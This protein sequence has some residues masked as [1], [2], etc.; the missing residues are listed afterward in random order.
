MLHSF[1][2][3]DGTVPE[4]ELVQGEDGDLYG[5]A[6]TGGVLGGGTIFK[7]SLSGT[8]T[9]LRALGGVG[10]GVGATPVGALIHAAD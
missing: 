10:G 1:S 2:G 3:S 8:F 7:I 4:A 6:S 5:T 9:V